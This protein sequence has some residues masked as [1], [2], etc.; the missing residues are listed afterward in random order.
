MSNIR[1]KF[2][3]RE[4]KF[5]S[6]FGTLSS[7]SKGR[8]VKDISCNVRTEFQRDKDRIIYSNAFRRLKY[9]T[10]VFLSPFGSQYRTR[11]THTI[12]VAQIARTISRAMH[13]NEDLAEAIAL[14][15]DLGHTPFGHS[16]ETALKEIF[17]KNFSHTNQSIRVVEVLEK[18][19]RG[20]NLSYE[21]LDGIK[22]HS[23]GS[24]AIFSENKNKKAITA[25][26]R[27]VRIA[28]IMAYLNHDLEDAL[29]SGV[30]KRK[31][32]P[33]SC[34][35]ILGKT[36]SKRANTMIFDLIFSSKT[37]NG[38][39]CL[40]LSNNVHKAMKDL[41]RFLYDNVYKAKNVH[42]EFVKAKK[43]LIEIFNYF[44]DDANILELKKNLKKME[45]SHILKNGTK[46][47]RVVCDYISSMT[48]THAMNLY[49]D[50]FFP[51]SFV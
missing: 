10:Q 48:D 39:L 35:E 15:H 47:D 12:E 6:P 3:R 2:E 31:D 43:I 22:K 1:K 23:K 50:V 29:R 49:S 45:I 40:L 24:G 17:S 18:N 36:H 19:G 20:L 9:K 7:K 27:V 25:E 38:E 14:G 42:S 16:G 13:L 26:G 46:K 37:K 33:K 28:D 41:R 11:L 30:I 5:I 51:K 4:E 32:I 34:I 8:A 21:V 44:I